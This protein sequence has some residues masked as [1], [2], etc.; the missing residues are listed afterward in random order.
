MDNSYL[1]YNSTQE[2]SSIQKSVISQNS[3]IYFKIGVNHRQDRKT[4]GQKG[5][6]G[7]RT[8]EGRQERENQTDQ[9]DYCASSHGTPAAS[10]T[11]TPANNC[12]RPDIR[13]ANNCY[14]KLPD[15]WPANNC[16]PLHKLPDTLMANNCLPLH[17]LPDTL[18]A[19]TIVNIYADF[20]LARK[21]LLKL[22]CIS[23]TLVPKMGHFQPILAYYLILLFLNGAEVPQKSLPS[24][25]NRF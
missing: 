6:K 7:D 16:L 10:G 8:R 5:S 12:Y 2:L 1:V 15:T 18:M 25:P 23:R 21:R 3:Q 13:P 11:S 17:K 4:K 24:P 20:T 9:A 14:R 22:H 19:K